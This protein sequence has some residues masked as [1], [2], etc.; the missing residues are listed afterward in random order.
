VV[1]AAAAEAD[2]PPAVAA[3]SE[4]AGTPSAVVAPI[5]GAS[6]AAASQAAASVGATLLEPTPSPRLTTV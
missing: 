4:A 3:I 2:T 5:L 1:V 6:Q